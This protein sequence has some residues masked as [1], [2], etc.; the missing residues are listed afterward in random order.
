[1]IR[2]TGLRAGNGEKCEKC[3][4]LNT[5]KRWLKDLYKGTQFVRRKNT[6]K[7]TLT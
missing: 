4:L 3:G 7:N 1:M 5:R 2:S 6:R